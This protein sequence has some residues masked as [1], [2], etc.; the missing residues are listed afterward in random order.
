MNGAEVKITGLEESG[1]KYVTLSVRS[2][3]IYRSFS[4]HDVNKGGEHELVPEECEDV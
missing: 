2:P 3:L 1:A 4:D